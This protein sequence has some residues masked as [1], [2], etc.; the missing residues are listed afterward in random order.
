MPGGFSFGHG[1]STKFLSPDNSWGFNKLNKAPESS[2]PTK[3]TRDQFP[4]FSVSQ[5]EAYH[6]LTF[7]D[8]L[9]IVPP[10]ADYCETYSIGAVTPGGFA[11]YGC[12]E[13]D[14]PCHCAN[15]QKLSDVKFALSSIVNL[16]PLMSF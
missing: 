1:L 10:C 6:C 12:H 8:L 15:S 14:F 3:H 7:A 9:N 2:I 4:Q 11:R 5:W 13:D 16:S